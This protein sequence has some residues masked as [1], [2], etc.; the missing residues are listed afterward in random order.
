MKQ[1]THFLLI[2]SLLMACHDKDIGCDQGEGNSFQVDDQEGVVFVDERF[3]K[4]IVTYHVEGTIDSFST[5]VL[6]NPPKDWKLEEGDRKDVVFS[7]Q[8]Q[9]L[10]ERYIPSVVIGGESFF[11]IFLDEI[12]LTE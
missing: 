12:K 7:G 5:F 10:K 11:V 2:V 8:A 4:M 1:F 3:G 9:A 6:C